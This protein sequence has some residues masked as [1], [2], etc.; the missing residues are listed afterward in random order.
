MIP[1]RV[2][3]EEREVNMDY[4]SNYLLKG[5]KNLSYKLCQRDYTMTKFTKDGRSLDW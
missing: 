5:S 1:N 3:I 2:K 4:K